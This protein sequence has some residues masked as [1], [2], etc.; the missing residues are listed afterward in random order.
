MNVK[1]NTH[2]Y[3]RITIHFKNRFLLTKNELK[4]NINLF[5]VSLTKINAFFKKK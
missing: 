5:I 3:E 2:A 1:M 4:C